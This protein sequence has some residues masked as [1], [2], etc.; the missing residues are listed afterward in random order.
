M[1]CQSEHS[2]HGFLLL[3]LEHAQ[4][5]LGTTP[6]RC[7]GGVHMPQASSGNAALCLGSLSISLAL[8]RWAGYAQG[9]RFVWPLALQKSGLTIPTHLSFLL[10]TVFSSLS[11]CYFV[12]LL[13]HRR[14]HICSMLRTL[15][16]VSFSLVV[17]GWKPRVLGMQSKCSAT[18]ALAARMLVGCKWGLAP[19]VVL[20]QLRFLLPAG[21]VG[22]RPAPGRPV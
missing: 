4:W 15:M 22:Y 5:Y 18:A 14:E 11:L 13:L 6:W 3:F 7:K 8:G 17:P 19:S 16:C 20:L 2:A 10:R 1:C 9:H 21:G 12:T